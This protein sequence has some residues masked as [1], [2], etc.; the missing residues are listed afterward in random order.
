MSKIQVD[1]SKSTGVIKPVH[2]VGQPPTLGWV[3]DSMFHFLTE[4]G[5]PYSRL[6]DTGGAFAGARFVDI[7]VVFPDFDADPDDPASYDFTFTDPLI[8][9]LQNAKVEPYYR[10]GVTIENEQWRK[11]YHIYPPKDFA[12]WAKICAGIIRHYT[13]GWG[14]GFHYKMTYWEIWNEPEDFEGSMMWKGTWDQY[15]DL[16]RVSSCYLKQE[17]PEIKIGG[18]ASCGFYALFPEHQNVPRNHKF[19]ECFERFLNFVK[20]N[21]CPFDFYSWHAYDE[22]L[23]IPVIADYVRKK[24]DEYGFVNTE[25]HLNEWN[26]GPM[27]RGKAC[28]AASTGGTLIAMQNSPVDVGAFYDARCG[29]SCYGGLFNPMTYQPLKAYYALTSFNELY[30]RKNQVYATSDTEN[31]FVAAAANEWDIAV[32]ISNF[33]G[34]EQPLELDLNGK[35]VVYGRIT[36]DTRDN[37]LTELPQTLPPYSILLLV[38]R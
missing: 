35:K 2:G 23:H 34:Q 14:N 29:T 4:A 18:Y 31:V 8:T 6:H 20:E 27:N 13:K 17:F 7:P 22:P 11:A 9:A 32:F 28:H 24:L 33:S 25:S 37:A 12:K 10:L 38:A 5:V 3:D 26:C 19:I 16:Y 36:D 30:Q 1:C 15:M 21:N